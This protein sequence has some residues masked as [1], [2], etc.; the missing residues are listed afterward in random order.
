MH[1]FNTGPDLSSLQLYVLSQTHKII[2]FV[3]LLS[4]IHDSLPA[5]KE[6]GTWG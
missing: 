2:V 6:D 4:T 1:A 3:H 5:P